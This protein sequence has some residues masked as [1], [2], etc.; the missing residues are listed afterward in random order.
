MF[1]YLFIISLNKLPHPISVSCF[2][3]L[4][5]TRSVSSTMQCKGRGCS[6]RC[7]RDG[8]RPGRKHQPCSWGRL[9]QT[10][11]LCPGDGQC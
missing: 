11:E 2:G 10:A 6:R 5:I 1:I 9:K 4:Q 7:H 8:S 3:L